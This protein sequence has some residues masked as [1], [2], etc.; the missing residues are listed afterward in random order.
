MYS[1]PLTTIGKYSD[2]KGGD[3]V[4]PPTVK[5][6]TIPD[7]SRIPPKKEVSFPKE[8]EEVV[9]DEDDDDDDDDELKRMRI[10]NLLMRDDIAKKYKQSSDDMKE[11]KIEELE[12]SALAELEQTVSAMA[13]SSTGTSVADSIIAGASTMAEKLL[14]IKEGAV[15]EKTSKDM[16][17]KADLTTALGQIFI[18]VGAG[19]RAFVLFS[20]DVAVAYAE[21]Y[22]PKVITVIKEETK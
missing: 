4:L 8:E 16:A 5:K 6:K 11:I 19:I 2:L 14:R 9:E 7:L 1:L 21:S 18:R 20:T 12:G 10:R 15:K 3:V 13:I 17:L 22:T